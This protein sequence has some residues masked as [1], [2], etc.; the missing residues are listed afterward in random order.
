MFLG[1]LGATSPLS[2]AQTK[3]NLV[4]SKAQQL[5][6]HNLLFDP[7]STEVLKKGKLWY[8]GKVDFFQLP[9]ETEHFQDRPAPSALLTE[10]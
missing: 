8:C 3:A 4:Q 5:T 1:D 9:V 10:P 7:N 6:H 2:I